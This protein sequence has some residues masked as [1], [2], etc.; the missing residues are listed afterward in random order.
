MPN[1]TREDFRI[2]E[3]RKPQSIKTFGLVNVPYERPERPLFTSQ[4]I[5]PDVVHNAPGSDG[6]LYVLVLDDLHT[7]PIRSQRVRN[8]ARKF[9]EENLSANDLAAV[10]IIG[11]SDAAQE[12]TG[13]RRLLLAAVDKFLGQQPRSAT[14]EKIEAYN[15]GVGIGALDPGG[16]VSD[17]SLPERLSNIRRSF[18]TLTRLAEW[19]GPIQGRRKAL[20]YFSEGFG[21]D[22]GDVLGGLDSATQ[23]RKPDLIEI[24]D[25]TRDV[26]G[27]ATRNDVNIYAVDPR[28]LTA[29]T[30]ELIA[31]GNLAD[32]GMPANASDPNFGNNSAMFRSDLGSRS[33]NR[34]L[35]TAHDNL[36]KLSEDTGGFATLSSNDFT[37]AFTRIMEENSSYYILGYYSSN[38]KRDGKYRAIDVRLAGRPRFVVRAR[39]GYLAPRGNTQTSATPAAE[40]PDVSVQLRDVL[41]SPIPLRGLTLSATAATFRGIQPNNTVVVTAEVNAADLGLVDKGGIYTGDLAVA[42]VVIDGEG[43]HR[44]SAAPTLALQFRR[45]TYRPL[46]ESGRFRI[47]AQFALAPGRYQLRAAALAAA[48]QNSGS[49]QYDLEVPDFAKAR[50]SL[51]SVALV[52]SR[53]SQWPAATDNH[54]DRQLP[55]PTTLREFSI[56]DELTSYVEA[57]ASPQTPVHTVDVITTVRSSDGRVVFNAEEE[58]S[59]DQRRRAALGVSTRIPLKGLAPGLYVLMV[60]ARARAN[61]SDPVRQVLQFRVQ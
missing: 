49:V 46:A 58:R 40:G 30:D 12:L 57:Y 14:L 55:E 41:R 38:D 4:P 51:S 50:V 7:D 17:R 32:T 6:R 29:A 24:L 5:D 20:I 2:L 45:D 52:S 34:E 9:I 43:K 54:I 60:E 18:G 3:D 27:A 26:I 13:N 48:G 19:M 56:D 22:I 31:T 33:L 16:D 23:P 10:T 11:R 28:G 44:A 35:Q 8:A 15:R 53:A 37:T 39:K 59:S 42:L 25:Q 36:R 1:L 21:Y 47:V 61:S